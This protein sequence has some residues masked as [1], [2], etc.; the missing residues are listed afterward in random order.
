MGGAF[1][2]VAVRAAHMQLSTRT[3]PWLAR[4]YHDI[5][6]QVVCITGTFH[7]GCM[8]AC[9]EVQE[10]FDQVPSYGDAEDLVTLKGIQVLYTAVPCMFAC[11][12]LDAEQKHNVGPRRASVRCKAP[13]V[14]VHDGLLP[15]VV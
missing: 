2:T 3:E 7:R 5:Q 15:I 12:C 1:A 6:V 14:R 11:E 8:H 9:R 10:A 4:I 13:C